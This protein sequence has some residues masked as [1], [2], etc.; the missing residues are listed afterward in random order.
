MTQQAQIPALQAH[1]AD[2]RRAL[3]GFPPSLMNTAPHP[4]SWTPAQVGDHLHRSM[5]DMPRVLEG[6]SREAGR[7]PEAMR[8]QL[9]AIFLDF[10]SRLKSPPDILPSEEALDP[11]MVLASLDEDLAGLVRVAETTDLSRLLTGFPFPGL[12]FLT[13]REWLIFAECHFR[14]HTRQLERI[15]SALLRGERAAALL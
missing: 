5:K 1:A 3:L 8:G 2:F 11:G 10:S 15:G 7:D 4:G 6:P 9:E 12:G 14:R 13:G